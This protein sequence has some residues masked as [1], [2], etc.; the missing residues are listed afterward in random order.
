MSVSFE[1]SA[2][3]RAL[4]GK[5][6]AR[7]LRRL[8]GRIPAVVYGGGKDAV[9]I[10]LDHNAILH[11]LDH[12]AVH[13]HILNLTVNG[14]QAESVVLKAVQRHVY[15]PEIIHVDFMRVSATEKLVMHVPLH[16]LG[17]E[18][19]PGTEAGGVVSKLMTDV[20]IKCLPADLPEFISVDI[21]HLEMDQSLHLTDI[22]LPAG[23]EFAQHDMDQ[24]HDHP[25]V[26]MHMPKVSKEA[27]DEEVAEEEAAAAEA[28]AEGD[29]D[30]QATDAAAE[31]DGESS[32]DAAESSDAGEDKPADS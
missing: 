22:K 25:I 12:E 10:T 9:S 32:E 23:V 2:E 5:A 13:S 17:E 30:A 27:I 31:G 8:E 6:A 18:S 1:F 26:S 7:R 29:A 3:T 21:S 11:A 16:F 19:A 14:G 15:K 28:A 4:H 24:A 20:E